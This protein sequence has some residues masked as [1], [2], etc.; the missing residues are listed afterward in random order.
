M[1]V[2]IPNGCGNTCRSVAKILITAIQVNSEPI[3]SKADT[4]S[5]CR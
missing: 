2:V 3:F 1:A 4:N 5:L